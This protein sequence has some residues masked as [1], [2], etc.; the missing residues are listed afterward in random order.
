M[1]QSLAQMHRDARKRT[2]RINK[3]ADFIISTRPKQP[4]AKSVNRKVKKI[5]KRQELKHVDTFFNAVELVANPG[6][7]QTILLNPLVQGDTNITRDGDNVTFTSIQIRLSL[8]G[9]PTAGFGALYRIIFFRDL[10]SNG[11]AP[12]A[13]QLLDN[14]VTTQFTDSPYNSDYTSRFRVIWDF[15]GVLQPTVPSTVVAG[16]TTQT[17]LSRKSWSSKRRLGFITNYGI[18]NAGTIADITKNSVYAL[19]LSEFSDASN[20]G[21]LLT[22]GVRMIYKDF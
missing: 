4:T 10:Q 14:S 15:R 16:I 1:S 17:I 19:F 22:G 2:R 18:S 7:T 11:T 20:E 13:A 8:L 9:V 12:T 21:P 5:Q 3:K 6:T